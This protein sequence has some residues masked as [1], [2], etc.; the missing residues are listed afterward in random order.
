MFGGTMATSA[1]LGSSEDEEPLLFAVLFRIWG[2][3]ILSILRINHQFG[4]TK[5]CHLR[6]CYQSFHISG[7]QKHKTERYWKEEQ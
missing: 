2:I 1:T 4:A 7:E 6:S 3:Y 5:M